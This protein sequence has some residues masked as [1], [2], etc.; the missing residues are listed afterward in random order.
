MAALGG[1]EFPAGIYAVSTMPSDLSQ[2]SQE[3]LTS[4][5]FEW[6]RGAALDRAGIQLHA[7]HRELMTRRVRR[8]IARY[9]WESIDEWL[10]QLVRWDERAGQLL[11]EAITIGHT[12]FFRTKWHFSIAS[13]H[14]LWALHRRD[15]ASVWSAGCASGQ[16]AYSAA[17]AF[18]DLLGDRASQVRLVASDIN[19]A[20]LAVARKGVYAV[21]RAVEKEVASFSRHVEPAGQAACIRVRDGLRDRVEFVQDNLALPGRRPWAPCDVIFCRNTLMYLHPL[22]REA[23]LERLAASLEPDGLLLIDPAESIGSD[24]AWFTSRGN[25]VCTLQARPA[26]GV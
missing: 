26:T 24:S 10:A 12:K 18:D 20:S 4:S 9:R 3:P 23:V 15:R 8:L 5:Q 16:E 13:E 2:D 11:I 1:P 22:C 17:M 14:V 7:R 25:G 6:V 21:E 19:E